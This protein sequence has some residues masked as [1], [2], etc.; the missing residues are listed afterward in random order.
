MENLFPPV[1]VFVGLSLGPGGPHHGA[2]P[3]CGALSLAW[4]LQPR[5]EPAALQSFLLP[6]PSLPCCP[7]GSPPPRRA[8]AAELSEVGCGEQTQS[9][10]LSVKGL[11]GT[12]GSLLTLCRKPLAPRLGQCGDRWHWQVFPRGRRCPAV[13]MAPWRCLRPWTPRVG[14]GWVAPRGNQKTEHALTVGGQPR[15]LLCLWRRAQPLDMETDP[16]TGRL[17]GH[18]RW[19]GLRPQSWPSTLV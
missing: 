1:V 15:S 3:V 16:T 2:Q 13:W 5:P 18:L 7:E 19:Q 8:L 17:G 4:R 12:P 10:S 14:T 9:L 6:R 11:L